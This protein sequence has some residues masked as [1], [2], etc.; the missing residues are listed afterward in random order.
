[1][2]TTAE[3][4]HAPLPTRLRKMVAETGVVQK[5]LADAVGVKPQSISQ[6]LDGT[7][8]PS[9][10]VLVA[11]SDFFGV[12][13]DYLLGRTD[14]ETTN[15]SIAAV[16]SATGLPTAGIELLHQ[17]KKVRLMVSRI[18]SDPAAVQLAQ[19][20]GYF[21]SYA[22]A[23]RNI[24]NMVERE[25]DKNE[26]QVLIN[27]M[28]LLQDKEGAFRREACTII[29]AIFLP[30]ANE[31]PYTEEIPL[32]RAV[33]ESIVDMIP[34]KELTPE[35]RAIIEKVRATSSDGQAF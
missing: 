4:R 26:R 19:S 10:A 29:E 28:L 34:D 32:S 23:K 33:F 21:N 5:E 6:Y 24:A 8:N 7:V 14:I 27:E 25:S 15:Q 2:A 16:A 3:K 13:T 9:Y 20:L 11:L 31:Q 35:L 1:M 30:A 22:Y 12:S 18:L 17:N